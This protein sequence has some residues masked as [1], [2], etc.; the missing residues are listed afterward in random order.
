MLDNVELDH[1]DTDIEVLDNVVHVVELVAVCLMLYMHCAS[2]C[3]Q[4]WMQNVI[5][6]WAQDFTVFVNAC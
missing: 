2:N 5:D 4:R 6:T 3:V 1:I